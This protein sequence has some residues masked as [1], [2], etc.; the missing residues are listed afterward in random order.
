M[1]E[2]GKFVGG[3]KAAGVEFFAGVPMKFPCDAAV[4][5]GAFVSMTVSM[6]CIKRGRPF[7]PHR[8]GCR[9]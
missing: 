1:I 6:N 5:T 8:S 9:R 3:L 7:R 2:A 4:Q